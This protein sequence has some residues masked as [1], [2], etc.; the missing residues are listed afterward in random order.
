[1][2]PY[3]SYGILIKDFLKILCLNNNITHKLGQKSL[4]LITAGTCRIIQ[5][6][7]MDLSNMFTC[8]PKLSKIMYEMIGRVGGWL[9]N[10]Y[11]CVQVYTIQ[12]GELR[13]QQVIQSIYRLG[14]CS[15]FLCH[16]LDMPYHNTLC[17]TLRM[18]LW[19]E[20]HSELS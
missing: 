3:F 10:I 2:I 9:R 1:M 12:A 20:S 17:S 14:L 15:L 8:I 6:T 16:I 19:Y 5:Q 13:Q 4:S 11:S 18:V 7:S